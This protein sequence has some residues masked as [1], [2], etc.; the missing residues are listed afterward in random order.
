MI[1]PQSK[2]QS[3]LQA[4]AAVHFASHCRSF[5]IS[6]VSSGGSLVQI[7]LRVLRGPK[8]CVLCVEG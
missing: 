2:R 6:T 3:R 4:L 5:Y 1:A 7:P 8:L